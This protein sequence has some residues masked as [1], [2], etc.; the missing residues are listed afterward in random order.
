MD[1]LLRLKISLCDLKA[2]SRTNTNDELEA[3]D[4]IVPTPAKSKSAIDELQRMY[5]R[6][7]N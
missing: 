4:C 3:F 1:E 7:I 2:A 5:L 6:H